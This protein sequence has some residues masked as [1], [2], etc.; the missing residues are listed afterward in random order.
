MNP[1]DPASGAPTPSKTPMTD[2]QI[3]RLQ[4]ALNRACKSGKWEARIDNVPASFA[5]AL[6]SQNAEL[7]A[8]LEAIETICTESAGNC[9][10]RM[11][12]RVGNILVAARAALKNSKNTNL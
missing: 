11:G 8:A 9:R 2:A 6:E 12:T 3:A 4:K 10:K 5:R 7:R 1:T